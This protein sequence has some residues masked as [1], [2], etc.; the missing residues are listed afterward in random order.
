VVNQG[1][2][3]KKFEAQWMREKGFR[4][5]V[6]KTWFEASLVVPVGN[7]LAKLGQLHGAMHAWD[8][9]VVQT[10]KKNS[11]KPSKNLIKR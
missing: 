2:K 8:A 6:E 3:S 10:P 4:E 11:R 1:K 9:S 7:V 5:M